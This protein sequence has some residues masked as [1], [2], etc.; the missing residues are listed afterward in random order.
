MRKAS[1]STQLD[2]LRRDFTKVTKERQAWATKARKLEAENT[3]WATRFDALL[4]HLTEIGAAPA[5]TKPKRELNGEP[6]HDL[7]VLLEEAGA[8]VQIGL[9]AQGHMPIV[10]RMI[11]YGFDW[12]EIGKQI[13]WSG[14]AVREWYERESAAP[15]VSRETEGKP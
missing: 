11:A 12:Y 8:T 4:K 7:G 13:G 6:C 15:A 5:V 10:E 1:D 3:R 2:R 9:R 14:D